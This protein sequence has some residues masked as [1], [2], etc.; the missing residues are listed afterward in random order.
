MIKFLS[1]LL[2]RGMAEPEVCDAE[3]FCGENERERFVN[4]VRSFVDDVDWRNK[5]PSVELLSAEELLPFGKNLREMA[6]LAVNED[7]LPTVF[8]CISRRIRKEIGQ[9]SNDDRCDADAKLLDE[10]ASALESC[11]GGSTNI[12]CAMKAGE[13]ARLLQSRLKGTVLKGVLA[14]LAE[15]LTKV[16]E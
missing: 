9:C 12:D 11:Q 10:L 3:S 5:N 14:A 16:S 8:R 15:S 2:K 1:L 7:F 6:Q 4:S 13:I